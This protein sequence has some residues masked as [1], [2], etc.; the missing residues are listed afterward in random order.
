ME[1][2][3]MSNTRISAMSEPSPSRALP[4]TDVAQAVLRKVS[5]VRML[6]KSPMGACLRLN[7]WL[8]DRLPPSMTA[9]RPIR[10]YGRLL[11]ALVRLEANREMYLGTFFLRNRPELELIRRLSNALTARGRPTRIAVLGCSNGAEVYS[12]AWAVRSA[13]TGGAI[14]IAAVDISEQALRCAREGVYPLGFSEVVREAVCER[15]SVEEMAQMFDREGDQLWIKPRLKEGITWHAADAT[16]P[17]L[18]KAIG[19]QDIVVA[20]RFLC[21]MQPREAERCLRSIAS[22]VRPGGY[23]FVSGIDLDVR[24]TVANELGWRPCGELLEEIHDGD[25]SL[26]RAWPCRYWGLEPIDK[27]RRDW[28]VRYASVFQLGDGD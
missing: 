9:R 25:A 10:S 16:D 21:H 19:P 6:G 14:A 22:L 5:Q 3:S 17:R 15:L 23:L 12:I 20:N 2:L 24:T 27:R 26:T 18:L 8:W 1:G 4:G 7:E 13:A 11:N 28:P